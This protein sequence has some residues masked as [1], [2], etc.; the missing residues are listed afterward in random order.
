MEKYENNFNQINSEIKRLNKDITVKKIDSIKTS[1]TKI[2]DVL[3][4]IKTTIID[5]NDNLKKE[6][7]NIKINNNND[8]I[9][10]NK[11]LEEIKIECDNNL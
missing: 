8:Y 5:F 11:K 10:L 6:V 7:D 9:K 2:N 4:N 1:D 3:E